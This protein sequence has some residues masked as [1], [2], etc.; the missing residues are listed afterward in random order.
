MYE[1]VETKSA[2]LD[3]KPLSLKERLEKEQKDLNNRLYE[4]NK[5]I[6]LLDQ[7]PIIT[8]VLEQISKITYLR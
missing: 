3:V 1:A 8:E 4:V 7:N 2:F 5:A 6:Q